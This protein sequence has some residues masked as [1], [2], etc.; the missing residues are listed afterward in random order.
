MIYFFLLK[1][2]LELFVSFLSKL[3]LWVVLTNFVSFFLSHLYVH[4]IGQGFGTGVINT[5]VSVSP[6]LLAFVCVSSMC[7]LWEASAPLCCVSVY[8]QAPLKFSAVCAS[9]SKV[10]LTVS[11]L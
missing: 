3:L 6:A 8:F 2:Y 10:I 1:T 11:I 9:L 7:L 4:N 5:A